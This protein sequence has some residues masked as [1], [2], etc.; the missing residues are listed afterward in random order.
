MQFKLKKL[1]FTIVDV[2][3]VQPLSCVEEEKEL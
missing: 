1:N 3:P 2:T